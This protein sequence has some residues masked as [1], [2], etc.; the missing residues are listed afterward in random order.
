L[1]NGLTAQYPADVV[2]VIRV[3]MPHEEDAEEHGMPIEEDLLFVQAYDYVHKGAQEHPLV[4]GTPYMY[5]TDDLHLIPTSMVGRPALMVPNATPDT[6]REP[7]AVRMSTGV[8]G[9]KVVRT[10]FFWLD[11]DL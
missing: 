9:P 2:C 7:N 6:G 1:G 3:A 10:H 4:P 5:L 11:R 8:V